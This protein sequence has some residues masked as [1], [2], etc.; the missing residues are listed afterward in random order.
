MRGR[1][2][3]P[4]PDAIDKTDPGKGGE[5]DP[6]KDTDKREVGERTK[7]DGQIGKPEEPKDGDKG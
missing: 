7:E 2:V 3:L 1:I 4:D 5:D 6:S